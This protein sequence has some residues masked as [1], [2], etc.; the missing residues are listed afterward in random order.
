MLLRLQR[1]RHRGKVSKPTGPQVSRDHLKGLRFSCLESL[2]QEHC[3]TG[4]RQRYGKEEP[5]LP[6]GHVLIQSSSRSVIAAGWTGLGPYPCLLC[7][8]YSEQV[9]FPLLSFSLPPFLT[10]PTGLCQTL[11]SIFQV[12][13]TG[14]FNLH[15]NP[16][17][18]MQ[19]LI[20]CFR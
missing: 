6:L 16:S 1:Q 3:V 10:S 20:L 8:S 15:S 19:L 5:W 2:C 7:F 9:F 11:F 18:E 13:N 4:R 14:S 17:E 12:S